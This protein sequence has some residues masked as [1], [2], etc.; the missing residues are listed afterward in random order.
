MD[1]KKNCVGSKKYSG[2]TAEVVLTALENVLQKIAEAKI[3]I[4]KK[5]Y[6]LVELKIYQTYL[7][8]IDCFADLADMDTVIE[9]EIPKYQK[10]IVLKNIRIFE[11][12]HEDTYQGIGGPAT[13]GI[14]YS[15]T[16]E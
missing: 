1:E 8:S 16:Y 11:N 5:E 2:I 14:T 7:E 6:E 9:S 4:A 12:T 3:V 10:E 15:Y 13:S